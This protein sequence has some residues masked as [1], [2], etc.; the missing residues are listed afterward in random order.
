MATSAIS[1]L[2]AT[3]T[4]TPEALQETPDSSQGDFALWEKEWKEVNSSSGASGSSSASSAGSSL[5]SGM[6][7]ALLPILS[8]LIAWMSKAMSS[9]GESGGDNGGG[10]M[11]PLSYSTGGSGGQ[12]D[13]NVPKVSGDNPAAIAEGLKGRSADS[14]VANQDVMMDHGISDHEDCANF[15]SGCLVKSGEISAS[16][17]TDSVATL[18]DELLYKD[19]WHKE[20]KGQV[21]PG[22]ICIIGGDQHV[23]IVAGIKNGQVELVGSNNTRADGS[24]Q[25]GFDASSGNRGNVEF[26]SK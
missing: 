13:P 19:G 16:Q 4:K 26:L 10:V 11:Q 6:I 17:H 2:P 22:D 24:Q 18:H 20:S 3:F 8:A 25:V 5:D 9:D 21:K 12:G 23:E 14:I 7:S 15:A 1:Y